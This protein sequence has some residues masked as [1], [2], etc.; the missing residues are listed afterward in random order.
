MLKARPNQ[1]VPNRSMNT[2]GSTIAASAISAPSVLP[3]LGAMRW[4]FSKLQIPRF[5]R[6]N[7]S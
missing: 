7:K 6:D 5:A 2:K 4:M 3:S 1:T